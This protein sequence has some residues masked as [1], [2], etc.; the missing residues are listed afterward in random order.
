MEVTLSSSSSSSSSLGLPVLLVVE[1]IMPYLDRE[2]WNSCCSVSKDLYHTALLGRPPPWPHQRFEH[3][4]CK[5]V[6]FSPDGNYLAVGVFVPIANGEIHLYDVRH[7]KLPL[8]HTERYRLDLLEWPSKDTLICTDFE[9]IQIW[10]VQDIKSSTLRVSWNAEEEFRCIAATPSTLAIGH[11]NGNVT[12]WSI[13]EGHQQILLEKHSTV[14]KT[15]RFVPDDRLVSV[16]NGD[17]VSVWNLNHTSMVEEQQRREGND[18]EEEE[19]NPKCFEMITN[20]VPVEITPNGSHAA[21]AS[22]DRSVS[23]TTHGSHILEE[24]AI[25]LWDLIDESS[26]EC[27]DDG[28]D[29]NDNNGSTKKKKYVSHVDCDDH[30]L[31]LTSISFS[32]DGQKMTS[33]SFDGSIC[34]WNLYNG[35]CEKVLKGHDHHALRSEFSSDGKALVS[36]SYHEFRIW[37][38]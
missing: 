6:T 34:I 3:E 1:H 10:N 26:Y 19:E 17:L 21:I 13:P 25:W 14:V 28:D 7:G 23:I 31:P 37:N 5:A 30:D 4:Q 33:S 2:T 18:M 15:L 36:R 12:L 22:V 16:C 35:T 11:C 8:I 32:K 9:N 27:N 20:I 38:L 29:N 24:I